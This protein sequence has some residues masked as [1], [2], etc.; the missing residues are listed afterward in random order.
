MCLHNHKRVRKQC[1]SVE[2]LSLELV[3]HGH[4]SMW[5]LII[6]FS[7]SIA[8]VNAGFPQLLEK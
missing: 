6:R 3:T 4:V 1:I 2:M 7:K 8:K 5:L